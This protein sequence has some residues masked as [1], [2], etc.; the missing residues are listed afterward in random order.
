MQKPKSLQHLEL[1]TGA[2]I[3]KRFHL[4]VN[5]GDPESIRSLVRCMKAGNRNV[6]LLRNQVQSMHR[7]VIL[8]LVRGWADQV[9]GGG[10][11]M[12]KIGYRPSF[13]SDQKNVV[14]TIHFSFIN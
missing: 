12:T 13:Q 7:K 5:E 9:G 8:S 1:E 11:S 10:P 6:K 4:D 3:I 14:S 2:K